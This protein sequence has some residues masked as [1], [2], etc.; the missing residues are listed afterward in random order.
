MQ[1]TCAIFSSVALSGST[2]FFLHY[3]TKGTNLEKKSLNYKMCFDF[4]YKF[5]A[6]IS[7]V[8]RRTEEAVIINVYW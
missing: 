4:L 5:Y 1:S 7:L 8:F 2:I 6:K 3:F